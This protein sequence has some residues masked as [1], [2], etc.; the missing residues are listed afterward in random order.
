MLIPNFSSSRE[1]SDQQYELFSVD[2]IVGQHIRLNLLQ[3]PRA[4]NICAYV[5]IAHRVRALMK[6]S[7]IDTVEII[8]G[9]IL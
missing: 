2:I 1:L 8:F 5:H 3:N 7:L 6:I 4:M 9:D